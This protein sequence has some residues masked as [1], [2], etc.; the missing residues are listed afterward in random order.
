M[1]RFLALALTLAMVTLGLPS[2]SFAAG[3]Q[4]TGQVAG[5]AQTGAGSPIA[6]ATVRLR[7]TGTGEVAG[8]SR[9]AADGAYSFGN[10]PAGNY[11]VELVDANGA[12]TATSMPVS[13]A[14]GSMAVTGVAVTT[15]VGKA[16]VGA[17]AASS[18][19][20]FFTSTGGILLLAAAGGGAVAGIY[21]A[22][23]TTRPSQ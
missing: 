9:T 17:V 7:N 19:G 18:T 10:V 5:T 13:L 8:T 1:K 15:A 16:G 12:V 4:T 14:T 6:N 22:T 20:S 3:P 2:V 23:R 21:A 11:V